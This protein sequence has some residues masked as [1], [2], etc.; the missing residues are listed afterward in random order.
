VNEVIGTLSTVY[1]LL[2]EA[3]R[4]LSAICYV[5]SAVVIHTFVVTKLEH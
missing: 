5:L 2:L 1:L 4:L 3:E